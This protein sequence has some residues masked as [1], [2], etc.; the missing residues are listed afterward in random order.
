[1]RH[2]NGLAEQ[3]G[4]VVFRN[5]EFGREVWAGD[6]KLTIISILMTFKV[7]GTD[8]STKRMRVNREEDPRTELF[9]IISGLH[10]SILQA[11]LGENFRENVRKEI[12]N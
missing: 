3:A 10:N 8:V 12:D 7:F 2:L 9:Y 6:I 4:G 1:M 5:L 11:V